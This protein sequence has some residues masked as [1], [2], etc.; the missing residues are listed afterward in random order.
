VGS[1]SS[2]GDV[3]PFSEEDLLP[4]SALQHWTYCPRQCALIHLEQVWV[5][6]PFTV[7]G[8]HLHEKVDSAPGEW[9]EGTWTARGVPLR[10]FRL[11]LVGKADAVEFRP[12]SPDQ[13]GSERQVGV[14]LPGHPGPF[15]PYPVE[16]KRGRPKTSHRGDEVQLCAQALCLEEMLAVPVPE[17]ALYYG[18]TRRRKVVVIDAELRR[19]TEEAAL[20]VREL[21][22]GGS[23]PPA[24]L[25]PKCEHCSLLD[26]CRPD[27]VPRSARAWLARVL[28]RALREEPGEDPP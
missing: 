7:E 9:R 8:R 4:L 12:L 21:L 5:E 24:E 2:P 19:L 22:A 11:G 20:R 14:A 3:L 25:A 13:V 16:Y 10:S 18:K 6:N 26:I 28:E 1:A 27:A 17:G 23:T 15:R